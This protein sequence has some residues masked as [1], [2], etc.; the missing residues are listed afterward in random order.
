[1]RIHTVDPSPLVEAA[2][3]RIERERM[4]GLPI[5]NHALRVEAVDFQPWQGH[6]LGMLVT[7][8]SMAVLLLPGSEEGWETPPENRRRPVAFPAGDFN[9]LGGEE[10]EIGEYQTC[11]L[12]ANMSQFPDQRQAQATARLSLAALLQP[13]PTAP[14]KSEAGQPSA[15]RRRFL[16]LGR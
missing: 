10:A 14:A 15:G 1:M 11:P 5:L 3:Q 2:F 16:T 8:W 12:F 7:P 6:W 4:A 9:F 13:P